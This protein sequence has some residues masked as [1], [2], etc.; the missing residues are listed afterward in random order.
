MLGWLSAEAALVSFLAQGFALL[1]AAGCIAV[2]WLVLKNLALARLLTGAWAIA[3]W[4][5]AVAALHLVARAVGARRENLVM[6][7]MGR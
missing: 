1:P 3:T 6:V 7:T 5:L 4:F 2:A